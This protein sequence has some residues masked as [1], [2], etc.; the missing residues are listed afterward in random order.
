MSQDNNA[1]PSDFQAEMLQLDGIKP[2]KQV[3]TVYHAPSEADILAKQLKRQALEK[4]LGSYQNHLTTESV[5]PIAPDD[6]IAYKKEGVQEGVFKN[7][8]LG[9]Y[10]ITRMLSL[11]GMKFKD[12]H[13]KV[14]HF[15]VDNYKFGNRAL[16]I[17]HGM[18]IHSKPYPGFYKS[19]I[20]VWLRSLPEVLAFHTAIKQ[21]GGYGAVYVLL[22]KNEQLK[23]DNREKHKSG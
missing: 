20:N 9:K 6:V 4:E 16:L 23:L 3:D 7:L 1:S 11:Q 2:L 15:I 10:D 17:K 12:A 8:R 13:E 14:F 19:Y 5:Q 18:G 21:H 22:K